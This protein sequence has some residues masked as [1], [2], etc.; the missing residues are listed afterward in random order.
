[1]SHIY[2]GVVGIDLSL[3]ST[4]LVRLERDGTVDHQSTVPT[5]PKSPLQNRQAT[6]V[7][8]IDEVFWSGDLVLIEGPSLGKFTGKAWDR[9][10]LAGIVKFRI[11]SVQGRYPLIIPPTMLKKFATGVGVGEKPAM[12]VAAFKRFGW[13]HKSNDV[14]DAFLLAQLGQMLIGRGP[15]PLAREVAVLKAAAVQLRL[16]EAKHG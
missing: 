15:T 14:T 11:W 12:A 10:E 16:E 13:E 8:A 9:A 6:I 5:S 7:S 4:G 2:G 1:V 3:T